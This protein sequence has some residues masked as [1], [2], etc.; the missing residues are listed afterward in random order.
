MRA[1]P[2]PVRRRLRRANPWSF[3]QLAVLRL[4][5]RQHVAADHHLLAGSDDRGLAREHLGRVDEDRVAAEA[6]DGESA[7]LELERRVLA[8]DLEVALEP[9]V[10]RDLL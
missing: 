10:D 6:R 8:A 3:R 2:R 9:Q 5:R 1:A 4:L 7:V